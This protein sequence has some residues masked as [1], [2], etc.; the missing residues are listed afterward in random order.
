MFFE[1][2][3]NAAAQN[4][5]YSNKN[6]F[7]YRYDSTPTKNIIKNIDELHPLKLDSN[8]P[9]G[10]CIKEYGL[11]RPKNDNIDLTLSR[12]C[13]NILICSIASEIV[14][15]VINLDEKEANNRLQRVIYI[16]NKYFLT[17]NQKKIT[18]VKELLI[19]LKKTL[20]YYSN[21]NDKNNDISPDE[22]IYYVKPGFLMN[23]LKHAI[24]C[25]SHFSAIIDNRDDISINSIRTI[26]SYIAS[27]TEEDLV[28]KVFTDLKKWKTLTTPTGKL[29]EFFEDY[30]NR[31]IDESYRKYKNLI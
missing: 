8:S 19:L 22:V 21:I 26:N 10:I 6:E 20:K 27:H 9:I 14:E 25:S 1:I 28:M 2:N 24:N 11:R 30:H 23:E 31:E 3:E 7:I 13:N 5:M 16:V 17:K 4:I 29:L 12:A 18:N 15:K